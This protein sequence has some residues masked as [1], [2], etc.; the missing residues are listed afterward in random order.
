MD[1]NTLYLFLYIGKGS[2][3]S[4][5]RVKKSTKGN[6]IPYNKPNDKWHLVYKTRY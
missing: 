4:K 5:I 2:M 3:K 6:F 1:I